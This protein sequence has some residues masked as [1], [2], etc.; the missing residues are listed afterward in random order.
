MA[1]GGMVVIV[2][3]VEVGGHDADIVSAVLAVQ[4][5]AVFQA[6]D[7]GQGVGLVG[8][9]QLAGQQAAFL[10]GLG[11]HAGVDAGRAQ[12]FQ[13]FAAVL[14]GGVDSIHLQR[15]VVVHEV[16]QGL[17][18]GDDAAHLGRCQKDILRLF[19]GKESLHILLAAEVQFLVGTGDDIGIALA[20]QFPHD[21]AAHHA[22]MPG[23]IDLCVFL[24][25]NCI[26]L[27]LQRGKIWSVTI[28]L[29]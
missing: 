26:F 22:A 18:V 10:H 17:L 12:E 28:L 27:P 16:G 25:H 8:L 14:P 29:M 7:L 24:H 4:E 5:L 1:V 3:A 19:G 9:F 21:G 11:R 6:A 20:L 13:L 2:G 23:Y 15:H